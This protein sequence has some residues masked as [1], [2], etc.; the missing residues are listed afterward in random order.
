ML[1]ETA[2]YCTIDGESPVTENKRIDNKHL[3]RILINLVIYIL[4]FFKL[5][6][7]N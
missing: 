7:G 6:T 1:S 5:E 4:Y 2:E 3:I